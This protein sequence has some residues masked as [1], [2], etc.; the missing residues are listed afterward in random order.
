MGRMQYNSSADRRWQNRY[1]RIKERKE[2]VFDAETPREARRREKKTLY[3]T[4]N[5]NVER[6]VPDKVAVL[7]TSQNQVRRLYRAV[8]KRTP[9][10]TRWRSEDRLVEDYCYCI[11]D[12]AVGIISDGNFFLEEWTIR[13]E[14]KQYYIFNGFTIIDFCELL[15]VK[16]L[17]RVH[18]SEDPLESLFGI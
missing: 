18:V 12:P 8:A 10:Y 3:N 1:E 6:I 14:S 7:C 17:G 15:P 13:V 9:E 5:I 4:A 16:D 2:N 11:S